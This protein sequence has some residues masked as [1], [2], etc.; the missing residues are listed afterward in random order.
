M[1]KKLSNSE[2]KI[3]KMKVIKNE[4]EEKN[5]IFAMSQGHQIPI[6]CTFYHLEM[7]IVSMVNSFITNK[8]WA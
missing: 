1:S 3:K 4:M 8:L 2:Q 5:T 7:T 6:T